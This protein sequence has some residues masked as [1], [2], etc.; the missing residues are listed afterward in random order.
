MAS[1]AWENGRIG[2]RHRWWRVETGLAG[3]CRC[4]GLELRRWRR[5]GASDGGVDWREASVGGDL[6]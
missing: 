4:G 6:V 5:L 1:E 2:G 3:R